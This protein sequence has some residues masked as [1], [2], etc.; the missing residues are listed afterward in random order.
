M[1]EITFAI[2]FLIVLF[3]PILTGFSQEDLATKIMSAYHEKLEALNDFSADFVYNLQNPVSSVSISKKGVLNYAK[4]KYAIK[5][6]DQ[7]IFCDGKSIWMHRPGESEVIIMKN[8]PEEGLVFDQIFFLFGEEG[9][10]ARYVGRETI[11][12]RSFELLDL[13]NIN[14][15][16]DIY[17]ARLWINEH[18]NLPE[19]IASTDRRQT[20]TTFEFNNVQLDQGLPSSTFVFDTGNF[21]G[22]IYDERD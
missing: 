1:K 7:E 4:G 16:V 2:L 22:D 10:N 15:A 8:D 19:K 9:I 14:P 21:A 17:K 6:P 3:G 5:M 20:T 13:D 11:A 12:G 18:T